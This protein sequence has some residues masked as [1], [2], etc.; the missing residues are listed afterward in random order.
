[1]GVLTHWES[2][3]PSEKI[4]S[5]PNHIQICNWEHNEG[6][7]E[8][9]SESWQWGNIRRPLEYVSFEL[10]RPCRQRLAA[11]ER[12]GYREESEEQERNITI[13][14]AIEEQEME[15]H[16]AEL[17]ERDKKIKPTVRLPEGGD[18]ESHEPRRS[19]DPQKEEESTPPS[20]PSPAV[21]KEAR[22][23]IKTLE[24]IDA[25]KQKLDERD[26]RRKKGKFQKFQ[27]NPKKKKDKKKPQGK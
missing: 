2:D 10:E 3:L 1:M 21:T 12:I 19:L 8:S 14:R 9:G 5:G 6:G 11:P 20:S 18:P 24:I 27:T 25:E 26:E 16:K 23:A 4:S 15:R 7:S 22:K 13:R 17:L